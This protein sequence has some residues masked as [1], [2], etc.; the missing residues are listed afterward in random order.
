MASMVRRYQLD[1]A[2]GFFLAEG[3]VAAKRVGDS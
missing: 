1:D 3:P 2:N